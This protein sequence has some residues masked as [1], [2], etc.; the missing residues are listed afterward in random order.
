[1]KG[2]KIIMW[3]IGVIVLVIAI[4]LIWFNI[5]GSPLKSKF[6]LIIKES[7]RENNL[8]YSAIGN[9]IYTE[10]DIKNLPISVQK[11]FRYSGLIGKQ[12]IY[13]VHVV[14]GETDF[15]LSQ[16]KPMLKIKYEHY[17]LLNDLDRIASIQTSMMGIPFEGLDNYTNSIGSMTGM[18]AKSVTLFD[19]TGK[20][21]DISSLV[22]C[23]SE[24][25]FLPTVAL[26]EYVVWESI[27]QNTAK[28]TVTYNGNTVSAVF[29][30]KDDGEMLSAETDDRYMDEGNGKSS[31]QKWIVEASEYIEE[32][33]IKHP[34]KAKAIWKLD[35][36][37]YTYFDGKDIKI[38][39]N[40][41]E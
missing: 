10:E 2:R 11:F 1:M 14:Y 5:P 35:T 19:V 8:E 31:K 20:E 16:D 22:T 17:N 32:N 7:L 15:K 27:D 38:K 4:L 40:V 12:K 24:M 41:N 26:Q 9:E 39:Y 25:I 3:I 13:N 21:M 36:G 28:A 30:F 33:G 34:S 18:L 6:N 37:D 29:K 23:L